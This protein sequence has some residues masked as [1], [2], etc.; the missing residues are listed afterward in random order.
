MR[1]KNKY[2][3]CIVAL[4]VILSGCDDNYVSSI[5]NYP[6]NLQLN[7]TSTY[8]TFKNNPNSYLLF[9]KPITVSDRVGF[10][11]VLLYVDFDGDYY[12]FDLACPYEA[13]QN[14]KVI[15]NDD[16][17]G[18]VVCNTCG[19]VYNLTSGSGLPKEG[20]SKEPLKRYRT[21]PQG[22]WL[23]VFN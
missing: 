20:P 10:G 9:E 15:P 2:L 8:P 13:K 7:L 18:Q 23:Y 5:P 11:G 1:N 22:D 3:Y 12:A 4:M 16:S 17:F 21:S 19:S 14:I 6:V